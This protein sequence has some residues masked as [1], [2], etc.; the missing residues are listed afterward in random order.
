MTSSNSNSQYEVL[1]PWAEID[2]LPLKGISPRV[3]DLN[4]KKI[5]LFV[6]HKQAAPLITTVL[7]QK[8]K[9]RFPTAELSYWRELRGY[10]PG[11]I[12]HEIVGSPDQA[13]FEEWV[14]GVDTV[15]SFVG[16]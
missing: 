15:I 7:E 14:K 5:G 13:K 1:S 9:E 3:T 4:G 8:L 2:P 16:D 10:V 6:D 12:G 11:K